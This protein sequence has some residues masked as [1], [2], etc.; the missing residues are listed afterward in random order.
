MKLYCLFFLAISGIYQSLQPFPV[1]SKQD[2]ASVKRL[3]KKIYAQQKDNPSNLNDNHLQ[4]FL[5]ARAWAKDQGDNNEKLLSRFYIFYYYDT[6]VNNDSVIKMGNSLLSNQQFMELPESVATLEALNSAYS[7]MGFYKKQLEILPIYLEQN[8][9]H[10]YPVQPESFTGYLPLA[11]VYYNLEQYSKAR[12]TYR[13]QR[14]IFRDTGDLFREASMVNNI[15][16]TYEQENQMD[17]AIQSYKESIELLEADQQKDAF[18]PDAYKEYFKQVVQSNMASLRLKQGEVEGVREIF[19][20]ELQ[21]SIE[22]KEPRITSQAYYNLTEYYFKTNQNTKALEYNNKAIAAEK[23]HYSPALR[24]RIYKQR[25]K[26]MLERGSKKEALDYF[27]RS[28]MIRDSISQVRHAKDLDQA[29]LD[30]DFLQAQKEIERRN[31]LIERKTQT[32]LYQG[33]IIGFTLL[34]LG[35]FIVLFVRSRR[36]QKVDAQQRQQ[37]T[38]AVNQKQVMLDEI[39]HRIKNNLQVIAG[40]LELKLSD[41][42]HEPS[43]QAL[44]DSQ[45]YLQSMAYI[46]EQLYQQD[47]DTLL[48]MSDYFQK[49]VTH[50]TAQYNHINVTHEID[51]AQGTMRATDAT[52]LGLITCELLTNSLKHAFAKAGHIKIY[53]ANEGS[54]YLFKYSD[55]GAG[56]EH[57]HKDRSKSM[58]LR[59]IRLLEE[60]LDGKSTF[61]TMGRFKYQLLFKTSSL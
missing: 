53:L 35:L 50:I 24:H 13:K 30:Y 21:S 20:K 55:N 3:F 40:V 7:R 12:E 33:A 45:Q 32:T 41:K 61:E 57:Q 14:A 34:V 36:T 17:Q 15:G 49:L 56:F 19:E 25:G 27:S 16:L 60:E 11:L 23:K 58:G 46:H 8:K 43:Q 1:K 9:K 10:N 54:Q 51:A 6:Q 44:K 31:E 22:R 18:Y 4:Q 38:A 5:K 29:A 39:H 42:D 48:D 47:G 37:L 59:L 26:I 2:F 52:P 28:E